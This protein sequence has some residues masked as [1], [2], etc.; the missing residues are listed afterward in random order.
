MCHHGRGLG[1]GCNG[2]GLGGKCTGQ[3][4]TRNCPAPNVSSPRLRNLYIKKHPENG[5]WSYE[6]RPEGEPL[7][8]RDTWG[9][10]SRAPAGLGK[11][12]DPWASPQSSREKNKRKTA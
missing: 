12:R 8:G 4:H 11:L 9:G 2:R 6:D 5:G 1:L 3:T 10:A 7:M